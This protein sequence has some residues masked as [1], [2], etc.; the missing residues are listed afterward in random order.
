VWAPF[1]VLAFYSLELLTRSLRERLGAAL[2]S[3][4][5]MQVT[6]GFLVAICAAQVFVAAFLSPVFD[7]DAG[8]PGRE[9]LPALPVGAALA[10]WGLRHAERIGAALAAATLAASAWLLIGA[11]VGDGE[12]APPSGP[13]PWGGAETFVAVAVAA[14][15]A[16]LLLRDLWREAEF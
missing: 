16:F 15:G 2:P 10:A 14:T 6:A 12:L 8:F 1:G 5:D 7:D 9:L 13:L 11:R 3:V 4:V